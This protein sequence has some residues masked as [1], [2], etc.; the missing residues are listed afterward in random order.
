[1]AGETSSRRALLAGLLASACG[2]KRGTRYQGWL[3]VASGTEKEIAVADLASFRRIASIPLP[4]APDQLFQ[5]RGSVFAMCRDARAIVEIDVERFRFLGKIG[6]PGKPVAARLLLDS[7]NAIVLADEPGAL[8]SVDLP[9]RRVTGR[10]TLSGAPGDLDVSGPLAAIT[11]PAKNAVMRA[12]VPGMKLIGATDVGVSCN[13]VR[14]RRDGKTILAGAIAARE[15]VAIDSQSGKLLARLP[16]PV[17]PSRFCFNADGGQLF[18]TGTGQ[19]ALAIVSPFQNEVAE[20]ILAGHTPYG[21]AVSERR[22]LLFVTNPGSGDLT[23]LDIETRG[24]SA[25]VHVGETPGDVLLTPDGEYALVLD[26]RSGNVSVVRITSVLGRKVKTNPLFTVF[27]T[28][29]DAR[30]A[31]IVPFRT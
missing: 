11:L 1:M 27:P 30:S 10:L 18:V 16:L 17:S 5:F 24:L 21:M 7:G 28:A 3:F 22:N 25:S 26:Q 6:L 20:T 12:S 13:A 15:L 19:D 31:I 29:A 4:C 2:R 14:F 9:R 8:L 23:I